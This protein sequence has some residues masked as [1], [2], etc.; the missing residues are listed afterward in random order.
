MSIQIIVRNLGDKGF[1]L[2][3][4]FDSI[5]VLAKASLLLF[6]ASNDEVVDR[7]EHA[8]GTSYEFADFTYYNLA[9]I[10]LTVCQRNFLADKFL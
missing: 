2:G 1:E 9:A 6:E 4:H 5:G 10:H 7:F 3:H 8:V